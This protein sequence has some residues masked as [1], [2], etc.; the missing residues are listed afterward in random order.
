MS[1]SQGFDKGGGKRTIFSSSICRLRIVFTVSRIES[2]ILFLVISK[3][4]V[5]LLS[6]LEMGGQ[7]GSGLRQ[8]LT[9][10]VQL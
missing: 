4:L 7:G 3:A 5:R 10:L 9:I 6:S 1:V 2:F 8:T